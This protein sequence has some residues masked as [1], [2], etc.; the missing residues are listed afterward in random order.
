MAVKEEGVQAEVKEAEPM[1]AIN[2]G[3]AGAGGES[4]GTASGG[5][6]AQTNYAGESHCYHCGEEGHW[7]RNCPH[8][9]AEQQE[10]LHIAVEG[11][12]E[13]EDVESGHQLLH[14]SMLQADELPDNRAYLDGCSTVTAFKSKQYLENIRSVKRGVKINCNSGVMHTNEVGDYGTMNVWYIPDGIANIFSM[15]ELE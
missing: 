10:Q 15:N 14:V 13:Q 7:A 12:E 5:G 11:N 4:K 8:L 2:G 9:T 1:K 3:D 6:A